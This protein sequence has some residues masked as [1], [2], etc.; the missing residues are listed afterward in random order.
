M[1]MTFL[2]FQSNLYVVLAR[3]KNPK[4]SIHRDL[5]ETKKTKQKTPRPSAVFHGPYGAWIGLQT[6]RFSQMPQKRHLPK[7]SS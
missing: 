3:E 7:I 6:N 1:F 5:F 4:N 2:L